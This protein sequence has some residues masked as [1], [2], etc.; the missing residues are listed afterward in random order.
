MAEVGEG[1]WKILSSRHNSHELCSYGYEHERMPIN[2]L[3]GMNTEMQ[4]DASLSLSLVT[5]FLDLWEAWTTY[6]C[7]LLDEHLCLM[8]SVG[9]ILL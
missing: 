7:H 1:F 3:V 2:I 4:E 8:S 9:I 5:F 6:I